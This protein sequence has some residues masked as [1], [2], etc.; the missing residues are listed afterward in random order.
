[1]MLNRKWITKNQKTR[2]Y[3]TTVPIIGLTGGIATGKSTVAQLFRLK[4]IPVIDA[5]QL[6]KN[7]YKRK[8]TIDFIIINFPETVS[9]NEISFAKL[10]K[11]AFSSSE[12][13]KK[14]EN[15]IYTK[16]PSEFKKS[17]NAL[18]PSPFIIYDVP[19]L[20]EKGL[21]QFID[22]S[23]C[24]YLTSTIQI[25]RVMKRDNISRDLALTIISQQMNIE[26]KKDKSDFVI[27][28]LGTVEDL[29]KEF[30]IVFSKLLE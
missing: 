23:I 25:D 11:L 29:N 4:N 3:E 17:L 5:D 28:N 15:F 2:L 20:F 10:R 21:D 16:L 19:L 13:K 22:A 6:V 18:P 14:I 8:E 26:E 12:I 24:V 9:D 27:S 1:M 7:I 30:E